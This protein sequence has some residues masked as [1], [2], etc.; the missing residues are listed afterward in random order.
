MDKESIQKPG[1]SI[2]SAKWDRCVEHVKES[3]PGADPYAVCTAA[4]GEGS[5]KS[6]FS[7]AGLFQV[8]DQLA[9]SGKFDKSVD[10]SF[11]GKVP[12]S[13]LSRQDLEGEETTTKH[14]RHEGD[15]WN[16]YSI[17]TGKLLGSHKT[18]EG[19]ERQEAAI[20]AN[21]TQK[22][23]KDFLKADAL[24]K[25]DDFIEDEIEGEEE[26]RNVA[27]ETSDSSIAD[28][29]NEM[30]DEEGHHKEMLE[31][32]KEEME[33]DTTK[34]FKDKWGELNKNGHA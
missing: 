16:L 17:K 29:F 1:A 26:Y 9:K 32:M 5:F 3:S 10:T 27:E 7:D 11:A 24:P 20:E 23:F 22:T 12:N 25:M 28:R 31:D 8:A 2:H 15:K 21:K 14:I 4:L 13:K 18:K 6:Q 19:A 33:S 30:A 34:T